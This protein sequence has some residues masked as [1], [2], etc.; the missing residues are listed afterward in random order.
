MPSLEP[1]APGSVTTRI[2]QVRPEDLP[3]LHALVVELA[4]YERAPDS[5]LATVEDFR[6]ALFAPHP[7]VHALVAEVGGVAEVTEVSPDG[8]AD[9]VGIALWYV[10]FSTW[11][12]Q[13]GLWLEDLFVRPQYRGLGLGRQLLRELARICVRS[14]YT[15]LEWNVLDWNEPARGFYGKLGAETLDEWT[16]HRVSGEELVQLAAESASPSAPSPQR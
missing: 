6:A 13:H 4:V 8:Q 15:R 9:V 3:A 7:K 10:T 11:H 12:G 16:L 2:R 5:V 14:G 1:S